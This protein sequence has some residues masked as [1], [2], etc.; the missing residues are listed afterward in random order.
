MSTQHYRTVTIN[1]AE[2]GIEALFLAATTSIGGFLFGY[3]TGQISSL[4]LFKDFMNRFAHED[5][6]G[7]PYWQPMIQSLVVSI[8]SIGCLIGAL[9]GAW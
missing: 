3:D 8:M 5:A 7:T 4:I 1:G 6:D 2:C 9:L